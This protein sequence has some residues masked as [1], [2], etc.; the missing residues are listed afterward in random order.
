MQLLSSAQRSDRR[1]QGSWHI[2]RLETEKLSDVKGHYRKDPRPNC[3][4][5]HSQLRPGHSTCCDLRTT[6]ASGGL[7]ICALAWFRWYKPTIA[8]VR[9]PGATRIGS[10]G[11]DSQ[12]CYMA[13]ACQCLSTETIGTYGSE[14]LKGLQFRSGEP[15]AQNWQV[16][17]LNI[18]LVSCLRKNW[19]AAF[20]GTNIDA[21]PI[22]SDLQ[23]L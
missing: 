4:L 1:H 11:C 8:I 15:L 7:W 14:V 22:I 19:I 17:S 9:T 21:M 13:D 6:S 16:I 18:L 10:L 23:K 5:I 3:R 2:L 20:E 12:V